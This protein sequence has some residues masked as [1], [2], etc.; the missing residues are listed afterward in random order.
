MLSMRL[1][2]MTV[3]CLEEVD[4]V[5]GCFGRAE[6]VVGSVL[7]DFLA[8][9]G[10]AVGVVARIN[11]AYAYLGLDIPVTVENPGVAVAYAGSDHPALAAMILELAEIS[12]E[13][14]ER[15]IHV[16]EVILAADGVRCKEVAGEALAEPVASFGLNHPL[17]P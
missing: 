12:A 3:A 5:Y 2:V 4:N 8:A 9:V 13:E 1:M 14:G 16:A 17:F 6:V 7:F 10:A 15:Q 11:P